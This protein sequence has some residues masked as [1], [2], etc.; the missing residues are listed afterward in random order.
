V[1]HVSWME[2]QEFI[3]Q[4]NA[5]FHGKRVFRLPTEAEW[6]YA[7]RA[8]TQTP[9]NTGDCLDAGTEAN[10]NGSFPYTGCP[11][12]PLVGWTTPAGTYPPNA[13]ALYDMHGNVYEWCDDWYGAYS[14]DET[15]PVGQATGSERI[16]R[17][18]YWNYYALGCR[19]AYRVDTNPDNCQR[20]FGFRPVRTSN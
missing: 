16:L 18:G 17:G 4:L 10:Y 13:F 2:C 12:G 3:Q 9:F 15:D 20:S 5:R 8:G 7:C 14:G 19:S 6:E 1:E 11:S